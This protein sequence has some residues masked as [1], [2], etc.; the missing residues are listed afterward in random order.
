M[1]SIDSLGSPTG[2]HQPPGARRHLAMLVD[3]ENCS[4]LHL[5]A[6]LAQAAKHGDVTIRRI[7]GDWTRSGMANWKQPLQK[8]A[9]HPI[10]QFHHTA[11]K[12]ATDC[13]MIVDAMDLM[14]SGKV[15]GFCLASSDSDFTRLAIRLREEGCFVMGI[16]AAKTPAVLVAACD[17]FVFLPESSS[18]AGASSH[19]QQ[20]SGRAKAPAAQLPG[21]TPSDRPPAQT[22]QQFLGGA[23]GKPNPLPLLE[24][25]FA[26]LQIGHQWIDI[27]IVSSHLRKLDPD[28]RPQVYGYRQLSLLV[29]AQTSRFEVM[30]R[31]HSVLMRVRLGTLYP[32]SAVVPDSN[33]S[34]ATA[35]ETNCGTM[36]AQDNGQ[37]SNGCEPH[38]NG[39]VAYETG[40]ADEAPGPPL[41]AT[42]SGD[43]LSAASEGELAS[44]GSSHV[45]RLRDRAGDPVQPWLFDSE[46][47]Y[48]VE[49]SGVEGPPDP[50]DTPRRRHPK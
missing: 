32:R 3:G 17:E 24:A 43:S 21:P 5:A 16:G 8:M 6:M 50:Q 39:P 22:A 14:Y 7:Y 9:F 23:T 19:K 31:R 4:P 40:S 27:S 10:Q 46:E 1:S 33:G 15:Q 13:A 38:G 35:P 30:K 45:R 42:E 36:T 20:G 41:V 29:Q 12:N 49:I 11:G 34:Q 37:S 26:T 28:F 2:S 25:V 44:E 47:E 48:Y 18:G